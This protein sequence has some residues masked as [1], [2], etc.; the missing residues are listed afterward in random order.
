MEACN[1]GV[2]AEE[3]GFGGAGEFPVVG[4]SKVVRLYAQLTVPCFGE[5]PLEIV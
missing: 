5:S 4:D 1:P 2:V 3:H